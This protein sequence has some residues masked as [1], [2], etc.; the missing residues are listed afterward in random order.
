MTKTPTSDGPVFTN[1]PPIVVLTGFMGSGKTSAGKA[2]AELLHW[3]FVDLDG[4]IEKQEGVAIRQLFQQRGEAA[5][6]AIEHDVLRSCLASCATPTVV[7]LG[8]GTF[9]QAKNAEMI[10]ARHGMTVFLETPLDEMLQRCG[11]QEQ[12]DQENPRPL[13]A[14]AKAFRS[15]YEQ[16]LPYY[17]GASVTIETQGKGAAEIAREVAEKLELSRSV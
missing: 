1:A 6:R 2:L 3:D 9:V 15:L 5:F 10:Q 8:G 13:A 4:E 14:D 7:A 16:R 11:V 17:R 12:A